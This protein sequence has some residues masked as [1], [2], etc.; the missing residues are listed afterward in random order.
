MVY[1][2]IIA[3][4]AAIVLAIAYYFQVKDSRKQAGEQQQLLADYQQR[5]DEQQKLLDDYR[6][7]EK[8]FENV[9]QGYEQA[10]LAFDK[11][12][13][14]SQKAKKLNDALQQQLE[15]MRKAQSEQAEAASRKKAAA[16]SI[17]DQMRDAAKVTTDVRMVK[18][19]AQL[20]DLDD[21]D[22]GQ[23]PLAHNDNVMV[24]QIADDAVAAS[25]IDKVDYLTFVKNIS[26][27]ASAS[28]L[29]TDAP[30]AVRA[31]THLLD[32]AMK[33]TT[34]GSVVLTVNVDMDKMQ[35]IFTVE[36]TGTG[37]DGAEAEQI[38]EPYVK[39]NQ[40]FDGLGIGLTVARNNARRLGGDVVLDKEFN[41]S[42]SK[43]VLELP[44]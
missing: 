33:F 16:Q 39:L 22:D 25:G 14:D 42:G 32:N 17:I 18:L 28:M 27:D 8:N 21:V 38:F 40:Y 12:E 7:L 3:I 4:V 13:E 37:I 30:K 41:G 9:G 19:V 2:L 44:L 20:G 5:V 34:E 26:P 36:D 6:A 23:P 10:L 24:R 15:E 35:A 11:M 29:S 1:A 43:F 31:L